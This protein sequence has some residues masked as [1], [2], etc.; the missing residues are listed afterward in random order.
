MNY[1]EIIDESVEQL[2]ILVKKQKKALYEKDF[3]F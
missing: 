3:G 2:Q 1:A